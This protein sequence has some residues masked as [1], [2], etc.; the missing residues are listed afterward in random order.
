ME[1]RMVIPEP[2]NRERGHFFFFEIFQLADPA[3]AL[4][5]PSYSN[6]NVV[7]ALQ[8]ASY[9]FDIIPEHYKRV[10]EISV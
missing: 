6:R 8:F 5:A 1:Q 7:V 4:Q 2:E 3:M 9:R 10:F